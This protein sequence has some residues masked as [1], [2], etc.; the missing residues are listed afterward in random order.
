MRRRLATLLA[1]G[2]LLGS[3]LIVTGGI[4]LAANPAATLDQCAN[5]SASSPRKPAFA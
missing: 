5:G 1:V 4:A 2:A 3:M